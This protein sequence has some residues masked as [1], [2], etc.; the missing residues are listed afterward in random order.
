[1]EQWSKINFDHNQTKFEL[2]GGHKNQPCYS[3][4]FE[5]TNEN[6]PVQKFSGLSTECYSCHID[7][8]NKQ[9]EK[10]GVTECKNCHET[11][12]W[13]NSTFDHNTARFKLDGKHQQVAC[14]KCHKTI[15]TEQLT[16]VQYKLEDIRCEACHK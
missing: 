15:Q 16:Y 1:M 9:F 3:C 12:S 4:H 14:Y 10:E 5:K 8:H 13:K 11:I 2:T 6:S 7:Q